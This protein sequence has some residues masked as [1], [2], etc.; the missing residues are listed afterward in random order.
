MSSAT[1]DSRDEEYAELLAALDEAL[2]AGKAV[3]FNAI[4]PELQ[5]RLARDLVCLRLLDNA[6]NGSPEKTI[7]FPEASGPAGV[8]PCVPGYEILSELGRGGMGVVYQARQT[9]LP[10][11]VA[12][13]MVLTGVHAAPDALAR[14]R[15]EADLLARLPHP[16]IVTIYE[17]GEHDGFPF[18]ALELMEGGSLSARLASSPLPPAQAAGLVEALA[19]AVHFAHTRGILHRDVNPANVLLTADGV[20]KLSDFGLGRHLE[21]DG[22]GTRTGAILGT[23]CYMAPEQARGPAR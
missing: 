22:G 1:S 9:R 18:L 2:T 12:L 13:K 14:F 8:L 6:W 16:H 11:R 19:S 5:P 20:A 17:V 21:G 23:P 4:P 7:P 3:D 10:R 15:L